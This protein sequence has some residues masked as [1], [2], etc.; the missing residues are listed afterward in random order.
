MFSNGQKL[1]YTYCLVDP[2]LAPGAYVSFLHHH[3]ASPIFALHL[4][5]QLVDELDRTFDRVVDQ[6]DVCCV[7][8]H[9]G[10]W[11]LSGKVRLSNG[12]TLFAS[13]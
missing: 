1:L 2:D 13:L 8:A 9:G 6:R 4:V 7:L 3:T 12:Y 5:C 11:R 10:R